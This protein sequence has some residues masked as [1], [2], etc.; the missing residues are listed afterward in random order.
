[1]EK[2]K[3]RYD[4]D[5]DKNDASTLYNHTNMKVSVSAIEGFPFF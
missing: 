5:F 3:D 2:E 4:L 1:M